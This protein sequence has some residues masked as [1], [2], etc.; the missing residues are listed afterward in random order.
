MIGLIDYGAGNLRSVEFALERIGASFRRVARPAELE[1]VGRIVLP[2][3][4]AAESAMRELRATGLDAALRATDLPLLGV[5]LGMHLLTDSSDEGGGDVR[6]LERIAG[7][8]RRFAP[9][10][11][12]PQIGWNAVRLEPDP[13]FAGLG[14]EEHFYFLHSHR[15]VLERGATGGGGEPPRELPPRG[16][17][18]GEATY[19]GESFPAA[20]R[21]GRVAGVQ[22]HPEKSGGA[23][24]RLL[25]NFCRRDEAC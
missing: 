19:G 6:C 4:G 21:C 23:G 3:V 22:F 9:G 14:P 10:A 20:V 17:T 11:R 12:L 8:T 7:R 1:R 16:E 13:L 5:C 2:G 18:L 24:L 15:V 25:A